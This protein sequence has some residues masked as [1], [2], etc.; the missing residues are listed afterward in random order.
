MNCLKQKIGLSN[1]QGNPQ[2]LFEQIAAI[3]NQF[4][5]EIPEA[6]KIAMAIEK[7]PV[8][9]RSVLTAEMRKKGTG[10]TSSHIESAAF[11]HWRAMYGSFA[12]NPIIDND[13]TTTESNK[14]VALAAFSGTCHRCGKCGHKEADCYSKQHINGQP[15]GAKQGTNNPQQQNEQKHNAKGQSKT[16]FKGTCNYCSKYGHKEADCRKK[17]MKRKEMANKKQVL[18]L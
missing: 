13:T 12:S 7:L 11:Q 14:E 2:E 15:L 8:E 18:Q 17:L 3:E 9:Y 1:A 6:E 5:M 16:R 10:I 4:K